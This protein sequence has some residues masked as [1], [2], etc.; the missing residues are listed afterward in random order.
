VLQQLRLGI[1]GFCISLP[2]AGSYSQIVVFYVEDALMRLATEFKFAS[3]SDALACIRKP[4][5]RDSPNME[6]IHRAFNDAYRPPRFS[7]FSEP[8]FGRHTAAHHEKAHIRFSTTCGGF[9]DLC[10]C[11]KRNPQ[12]FERV[13]CWWYDVTTTEEDEWVWYAAGKPTTKFPYCLVQLVFSAEPGEPAKMFGR[14]DVAAGRAIAVGSK[15]DELLVLEGFKVPQSDLESTSIVNVVWSGDLL[16]IPSLVEERLGELT[17]ERA[18]VEQ[19]RS[20]VRIPAL[21]SPPAVAVPAAAPPHC[22]QEPNVPISIKMPPQPLRADQ[23]RHPLRRFTL[24]GACR[25]VDAPYIMQV[26]R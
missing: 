12:Q 10:R 9:L 17:S 26:A 13:A 5:D 15:F 18:T 7:K 4:Q 11:D 8:T 23:V 24:R 20:D 22:T 3:L 6:F 21:H 1:P 19:P 2:D 14:H 16:D 25:M